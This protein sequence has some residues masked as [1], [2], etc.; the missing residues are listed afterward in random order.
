MVGFGRSAALA[1]VVGAGV[2]VAVAFAA[3]GFPG[4]TVGFPDNTVRIDETIRVGGPE[5]IGAVA[6]LLGAFAEAGFTALTILWIIGPAL[7][8]HELQLRTGAAGVLRDAL[9]SFAPDPRILAL[10]VAWFFVLFMEG[11]AGFGASV[12]L[13]APFLVAA[14]FPPVGAVTL[15]LISHVVGVSFGAVGTPILPQMAATGAGGLE[16]ARAS[17]IYHTLLGW[18]PLAMMMLLAIRIAR[19]RG[20]PEAG[21]EGP[22]PVR[23]S[24][25]TDPSWQ[26]T[27]GW[28]AAAWICFTL[29]YTLLW[30]FVGPELPTLGGALFGGVFFLLL[31]RWRS[32]DK[33]REGPGGQAPGEAT[34]TGAVLRAAAPYL[35]LVGVVLSTR[36][37]PPLRD[38]LASPTLAWELHGTF[39]GSMAYLYHPG[40]VLLVGFV[41]GALLQRAGR[42]QLQAAILRATR[43]LLPVTVALLAML[44]LARV[45]VH[46]GMTE[47]LALAAAGAVGGMWPLAAPFVG[48]LGTFVTGSATASNI[49]FTDLQQETARALG[50]STVGMAGAQ[51]FG[52]ATGNMVCPH[53]VIAAGATVGLARREGEILRRTLPVSLLYASL[54][55]VLALWL[56]G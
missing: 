37:I 55:G 21:P 50:R 49:L 4:E 39:S 51:N 13:A 34:S 33:A 11:A 29:P 46:G 19:G 6:A 24:P 56:V 9:A 25:G 31:L 43:S 36:L 1:G 5:G 14:G 48:L 16:L 8:I 22:T 53:N 7:G 32:G 45:M 30:A 44:V 3:F 18:I 40:S 12:A 35:V 23:G 41:A 17:G 38:A 10:L 52:A 26:S 42:D 2:A 28:T 15:A 27:L 47:V 54:G 20:G